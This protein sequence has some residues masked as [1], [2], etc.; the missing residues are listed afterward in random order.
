MSRYISPVFQ[1]DDKNGAPRVGAKLVFYTPGT[2]NEKTIFSDAALTISQ[3]NPVTAVDSDA[4]AIYPDIFLNGL[5]DVVQ[6]DA[7][8]TIDTDDGVTL[9]TRPNVGEIA[10][11]PFQLWDS[12][13]IYSIPE[14]VLGSDDEYYRSLVDSNQGN[15]PTSSAVQWEQLRL[16]RIWNTNITY[17]VG[18]SVYASDGL[19]YVARVS[20]S[21]NDPAG[22]AD[23]VNWN[24]AIPHDT[25]AGAVNSIK[26]TDAATTVAPS[27]SVEGEDDIGLDINTKNSEQMLRL[28]PVPGG[29]NE[30]T[31]T[32]GA[33]GS[34][35]NVTLSATGDDT[36][37]DI[38]LTPK[39]TGVVNL[40]A[41]AIKQANLDTSTATVTQT[42]AGSANFTLS[43]G[44]YGFYPQVIRSTGSDNG[45]AQ[46]GLTFTNTAFVTNILLDSN[47]S[48][49]T[50]ARQRFINAS[51]PYDMG[52]GEIPL[53]IFLNIENG[54]G[55]IIGIYISEAAPWH[56]NG[57][58]YIGADFYKNKKGFQRRKDI[59]GLPL[60]E[61]ARNNP[62]IMIQ[63]M[64]GLINAPFVDF[65]ITQG[66][67][68]ADMSLIPHPFLGGA[69]DG[70]GNPRSTTPILL[71]PVSPLVLKLSEMAKQNISEITN[72]VVDGFIEFPAELPNRASPPGVMVHSIK[73]KP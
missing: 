25:I 40:T 4:G 46:I 30:I 71:D 73:M 27:I 16:G 51:S 42:G 63:Y 3:T 54:S 45:E 9:W 15:D 10:T 50:S 32:N 13:V 72:M 49:N 60:I 44:E 36:D 5:Y 14:I 69:W 33:T 22:S 52:D 26:T 7:S 65:E 24:G 59:S 1:I 19:L 68:N 29:V 31:V 58:T 62:A 28:R 17:G 41:A 70:A 43:G 55:D 8:G 48:G 21:G 56:Y 53:F 64:N 57:P 18:D 23:L 38:T 39:G 2:T 12:G 37:I 35:G 66:I 34:P 20:Q 11:V 47:I 6:Q 67:K 61:S